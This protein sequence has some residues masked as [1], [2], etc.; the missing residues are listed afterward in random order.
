MNKKTKVLALCL[1]LFTTMLMLVSC[2]STTLRKLEPQEGVQKVEL[3]G[4]CSLEVQDGVLRINFSS[5]LQ[6]GAIVR[7]TVDDYQGK[8]LAAIIEQAKQGNPEAFEALFNE[9]KNTA[10]G[11]GLRLLICPASIPIR[12]LPLVRWGIFFHI[13]HFLLQLL[14]LLALTPGIPQQKKSKSG[15]QY[16]ARQQLQEKLPNTRIPFHAFPPA[17]LLSP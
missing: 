15:Q 6:N 5:N 17:L 14:A 3:D 1:A 7:F 4:S 13:N 16:N 10:Y 9:F 12:R 2:G 11:I 8:E